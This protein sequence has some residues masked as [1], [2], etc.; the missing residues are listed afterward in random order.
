MTNKDL[1]IKNLQIENHHLQVTNNDLENKLNNI[2]EAITTVESEYKLKQHIPSEKLISKHK[3][4]CIH[5][6]RKQC[7]L[8]K[9]R[10]EHL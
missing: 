4:G 3:L 8:I 1:Q 5:E 10:E 9:I 6:I 2:I 7:E